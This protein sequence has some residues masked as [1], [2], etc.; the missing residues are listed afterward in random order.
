MSKIQQ[1]QRKVLKSRLFL[2]VLQ[3]V[4]KLNNSE[5]VKYLSLCQNRP[6]T[7]RKENKERLAN[8]CFNRFG[9]F[10]KCYASGLCT[11]LQ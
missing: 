2:R 11:Y 4:P 6:R 5:D 10:T 3:K 9:S 8:N 1:K 7:S